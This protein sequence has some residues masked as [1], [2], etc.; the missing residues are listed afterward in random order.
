MDKPT[1]I[2]ELEEYYGISLT[3][4]SSSFQN[5]S[6]SLNEN[7]EIVGLNLSKCQI[8]EIS[9][10]KDLVSLTILKLGENKISDISSLE[11]LVLLTNLNIEN[12]KISDISILEKLKLL[13]NLDLGSNEISDISSLRNLTSL[14][15]LALRNN[16]ISDISDLANLVNLRSL[17]L[18]INEIFDISVLANLK[19]L[20]TLYL[21]HNKISD[22]SSLENLKLLIILDLGFN[23]IS[24]ISILEHLTSITSLD[25]SRNNIMDISFLENLTSLTSL[26]LSGN[27]ISLINCLKKLE[28]LNTL[29]LSDNP[30]FDITPLKYL[31]KIKK[32]SLNNIAS[33]DFQILGQLT[34]LEE[35]FIASNDIY[36]I[37]FLGDLTDLKV[38]NLGK[39]NLSNLDVLRK[40]KKISKIFLNDN[41]ILDLEQFQFIV[42]IDS[43]FI[44]TNNNPCF[45][46]YDVEF[47][48]DKNHYDLVL[49]LIKKIDEEKKEYV[50][51]TKVL[52]LGNTGCG[53]STLLDYILQDINPKMFKNNLESTHI[54]QVETFPKKI[55]KNIIPEAVFYDF[56]GQDYY[57]GL[58]KA[59]L[60]NDSLNILL[61]DSQN[62]KNQIR[63]DRN[64]QLT[65]DYDR[66]YWLYQLKFQYSNSKKLNSTENTEPII[67]I[68]T[69]A[70]NE[71]VNRETYIGDCNNFNIIN[72]FYLSF[73]STAI[74]NNKTLDI[75]L[76]YF[77]ETLN[78]Q[79]KQKQIVKYEPIWYKDFLNYILRSKRKSYI[80]LEDLGLEYKRESDKNNYLLPEVLREIAQ[81]GLILYYKD[82]ADLKDIVWLNP[83]GIIEDIHNRILSK[84]IIKKN[85]GII[86]QEA[87]DKII[88]DDKVIKLL[89]NQKVI[90][91][92]EYDNNY[93]IPGYLPLTEEE[94]KLYELL[95]FDF[96][97]PNF[98]MKFEYF[99][100]FGLI[101]QLV[102]F[103]GK[104][105]NKKHYWRDQLL[106]TKDNSKILIKLDFTNLEISIS[107]KS[108]DDS[109]KIDKLQQEIFKDILDIYWDKTYEVKHKDIKEGNI[110][111]E[112]INSENLIDS[113]LKANVY[114]E[115]INYEF[116]SPDDLYISI[117][118]RY[119]VNHKDLENKN[120]TFNKIMSFGL[121]IKNETQNNK[122]IEIRRLDK[123]S[124]KEKATGLFKNF[125]NNKNAENMKKIF[126][127]YAKE[128]KREVNEF[129][130]QIAPFKLTKEVETWHCS[131][132]EL[133]EDWESKIK[134]KFYEA[135]IILYFI[136]SDFFS[137]PFILDEEV[138]RG[139][140]RNNDPN[141]NVVLIPIILEKIH[142]E[143]LLGKYTSNFKGKPINSYE[144]SNNVWYEIVDDLKKHH[145]RKTNPESTSGILGQS[146]EKMKA[147]EDSIS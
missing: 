100:P 95:T 8:S 98:V 21:W 117:D 94:D 118:N 114:N 124:F 24:D 122:E 45:D 64:E 82:D 125:T 92:D 72:E 133:G 28:K 44:T 86:N 130:K 34:S 57:H 56:G 15:S 32:I 47:E 62:D 142:W 12:N 93:I 91:L 16:Q 112:D 67:L 75:G 107:I 25:L 7:H 46:G 121:K 42:N 97:E 38:L 105:R 9:I 3:E 18:W 87:F 10:L 59:F 53:K 134:K 96:I 129:Q 52:L 138:K 110:N 19:N 65:R 137:T 132:L 2:L 89:I 40:F 6:Y 136:S 90:F 85:R 81:T 43:L 17:N 37:S 27:Q 116:V 141:D 147:Q 140:E 78:E 29:R 31:K 54:I 23:K 146:K 119:F 120:K 106:F 128:N 104:N 11:N 76:R 131:E 102:C 83:T 80:R 66:N 144:I 49:N 36:N 30:V 35:L 113:R 101:N 123:N 1:E 135:D 55:K 115:S 13:T 73:N 143:D 79:I 60:S 50:L 145:F 103:Y 51:P 26:E 70:D 126:I 74:K 58:Y 4:S 41:E 109:K 69:H 33:N 71:L 127:S 48:L 68:Q 84:D 88:K 139:I 5:N 63:K 14:D 22:I 77:E 99:L 39:N 111:I 20:T 108:K 61:W